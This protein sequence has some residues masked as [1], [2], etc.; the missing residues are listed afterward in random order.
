MNKLHIGHTNEK[1]QKLKKNKKSEKD[2]R[3]SIQIY[4][5]KLC[6]QTRT[7]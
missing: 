5:I 6:K 4:E 3:K 1:K 7:R 2:N